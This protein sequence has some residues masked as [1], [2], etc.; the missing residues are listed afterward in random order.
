M[1]CQVRI[2]A[3]DQAPHRP[4]DSTNQLTLTVN[5]YRNQHAPVF[6]NEPYDTNL[7]TV[8]YHIRPICRI[9]T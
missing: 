1:V 4:C 7:G 6:I 8:I 5:V 2:S 3:R 9:E